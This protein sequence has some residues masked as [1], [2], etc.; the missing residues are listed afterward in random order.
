VNSTAHVPRLGSRRHW[1]TGIVEIH[2]AAFRIAGQSLWPLFDLLLRIWLAQSFV[3][4]GMR[5]MMHAGSGASIVPRGHLMAW[6]SPLLESWSALSLEL[7]G[8]VALALGLFTQLAALALL[9]VI[10]ASAALP[11]S[12]AQLLMFAL[13]AWYLF[14][15]AGPLSLDYAFGGLASSALPLATPA[16]QVAAWLRCALAPRYLLLLRAWLA[17]ALLFEPLAAQGMQAFVGAIV[18]P[19]GIPFASAPQLG[20]VMSLAASIL[21]FAGAATRYVALALLL[22]VSLGAM[23]DLRHTAELYWILA[24]A[25][26]VLRGPGRWSV[27]ALIERRLRRSYPELEGKPAFSL[28][29]LPRVVIV[30]AGFGGLTCAMAL[31]RA[32]VAVTLIDRANHHLFQPLLYQVATAS[33]SPG[34]IATPIRPLFRDAF[35]IRVLYGAVSA[36]DPHAQMVHLS[37]ARVPYDYLVLASGAT[38]GYFGKDEWQALAPGLKRLEDATEIRR[39]LLTAFEKAE[40]TEDEAERRALLTFLIVGGGPTGV[41]LAGAIAE[42]ARLGMQKDFRQFD[43]S[44]ARI[45]LVQSAPRILPSFPE[46]LSVTAQR[47]LEELGVEVRTGRRVE[48]V[49]EAGASVSGERIP[50]RTVLWAAGVVASPAAR[51]LGAPSDRSGR[52]MVAPDL[53]VPGLSNVFAIGDTAASKGWSGQDVPGLA[54]AAKQ[55]GAYVARMI[56]A[57]ASGGAAPKA[58]AYHHRGSLAT[59]GRKAAVV[60]FGGV[61][62]WGAPA[63]WLWG[64]VHLGLLVGVRNRVATVV[65]WFWSYV[66]YK[67]AIRLIT[68]GDADRVS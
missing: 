65:N 56:R 9:L 10:L 60:H 30:G 58:F 37:A 53:S 35:N 15:G 55:G 3:M 49:D 27:D 62:L 36:V 48:M 32:P 26:I 5:Q 64:M 47:S 41:E 33:L 46:A 52:V 54:P 2:A 45:V 63:W 19:Q 22:R 24:L 57:R 14:S 20:F 31:R 44:G 21:L 51:W 39:R 43:P 4:S 12:D 11:A 1:L 13:I 18:P 25:L 42:L 16:L 61:R 66:T 7:V 50:A 6:T 59:I 17:A 28:E 40:V 34:D 23:M 29:G 38:H 67:S 68:G 8:A